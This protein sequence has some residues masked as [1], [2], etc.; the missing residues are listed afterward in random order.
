MSTEQGLI[1]LRLDGAVF[2]GA[3]NWSTE[4]YVKSQNLMVLE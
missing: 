3:I 2:S 1:Q 4:V